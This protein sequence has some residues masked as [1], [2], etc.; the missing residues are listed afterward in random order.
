VTGIILISAALLAAGLTFTMNWLALIPWRRTKSNHW[1]EQARNLYPVFAAA[2]SNILLIPGIFTL[3]V[4]L[5]WPDSSLLWL[6]TAII[7]FL[8]TYAGTLPLDHEVFPR[9]GLRDLL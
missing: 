5:L 6:F 7:S 4:L 1:S 2:R 8:G 3:T 9:I